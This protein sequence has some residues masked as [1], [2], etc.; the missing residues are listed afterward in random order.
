MNLS[1]VQEEIIRSYVLGKND[2]GI[3]GPTF[4]DLLLHEIEN[5][6][7]GLIQDAIVAETYHQLL[8]SGLEEDIK[9]STY[10]IREYCYNKNN[11][12]VA[13]SAK[14]F[15]L[16]GE[17]CI[18]PKVW[19][20]QVSD[21]LTVRDFVSTLIVA[22]FQH[23][24]VDSLSEDVRN[25]FFKLTFVAD[26]SFNERVNVIYIKRGAYSY[27]YNN[28]SV[29]SE[30]IRSFL[31][32]QLQKALIQSLDSNIGNDVIS[33]NAISSMRWAWSKK[34]G[35]IPFETRY[36]CR[37]PVAL[38]REKL[39]IKSHQLQSNTGYLRMNYSHFSSD[40][41]FLGRV[42]DFTFNFRQN[43]LK[44]DLECQESSSYS[45]LA[46]SNGKEIYYDMSDLVAVL[47][48]YFEIIQ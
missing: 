18:N 15:D 47:K 16:N 6:T 31:N 17:I 34:T 24:G 40:T 7:P 35:V 21:F 9:N 32:V 3:S 46:P 26:K 22:H 8:D 19:A 10:V 42:S 39:K 41:L 14:T 43:N 25:A 1:L 5:I 20:S 2:K 37:L 23:F 48:K 12:S 4:R 13:V 38:I 36:S 27:G 30:D 28:P 45:N 33:I 11:E 29:I 44:F